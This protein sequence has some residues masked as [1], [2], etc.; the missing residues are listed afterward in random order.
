MNIHHF[1]VTALGHTAELKFLQYPKVPAV[2]PPKKRP[3]IVICPGGG[4]TGLSPREADII[5][6]QFMARGFHAA[7]LDYTCAPAARFPVQLYQMAGA[8]AT[9]RQHAEELDIE[10]NSIIISGFSAGGHLAASLGVFWN[11]KEV[12]KDCPWTAE[13]RKPNLMLLGYPVISSGHLSHGGSFK[14]LL[15]E[16]YGQEEPMTLVSLEKQVTADTPATFLW[17]TWQDQVVPAENSMLFASALRENGVSLE[18]H[19]FEEGPHG[20]ATAN[21]LTN[22]KNYPAAE[23]WV[24]MAELWLKKHTEESIWNYQ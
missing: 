12:M 5:G 10:K 24:D 6:L 22:V 14:A 20:I 3:V 8:V 21:M 4:Y 19:M 11:N 18:L 9:L 2:K 7:V 13:E 1:E 15:G 23:H 17:H 16:K